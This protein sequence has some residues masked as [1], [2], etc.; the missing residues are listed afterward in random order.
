MLPNFIIIGAG[1]SGTTTIYEWLR[2]HPEVYMSPVKE[3]N[4]FALEGLDINSIGTDPKQLQHYPWSV[5]NRQAY[6]ELFAAAT[7]EK[8]IGEVSPMYLYSP[9]AAAAIKNTIPQVKIVAILRQPVDRLHS[10]FMHLARE[11]REP[12]ENYDQV[13][14]K[15]SIWWQRDDLVREGLYGQYLRRYFELFDPENIRIF[16]YEDLRHNPERL[17]RQLFDFLDVDV[18]FRVDT[19]TKFNP[20]G[21]IRNQFLDQLIGQNSRLKSALGTIAPSLL[22]TLKESSI[23]R[24][25][26][27]R[28]RAANLEKSPISADLRKAMIDRVYGPEIQ[29]TARL[30]GRDLSH[31]M[32]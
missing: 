18:S 16:L 31:W 27:M 9:K 26:L 15:N 11:S 12:A 8:A 3:T 14:D 10:R 13:F 20:S 5:T 30:L 28:W 1:K 6:E 23:A 21:R 25:N 32:N 2:Q 17:M 29:E 4:F 24:K 7:N 22:R 19:A